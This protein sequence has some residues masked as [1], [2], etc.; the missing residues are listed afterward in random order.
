MSKKSYKSEGK[1][2]VL[3]NL[4]SDP[5]VIIDQKGLFLMANDMF[6]KET[7]LNPKEL[8]GK[9]FLNLDI[10]P[11]KSNAVLLENLSAKLQGVNVTPYEIQFTNASGEARFIEVKGKIISYAGQPADLVVFH[12]VTRTKENARRLKEYAERMEALVAEKVKEIKESEEKFRAISTYAKDAI[13]AADSEGEIVY[14]N[15]AAERIF[16]YSQ[17][18]VVGKSVLNLIIPPRNRG[19]QQIFVQQV[20]NRQL[21]QGKILEFTALRKDGTEFPAELSAAMMNFENKSCLLGIV[22]DVSERKKAEEALRASE[23]KLRAITNSVFDAVCLFDEEDTIIHWNAAAERIFGYAEKE[24]VGKKVS[25]T[26]VPARFRKAHCELAGKIAKG[27][28]KSAGQIWEFPALKKD[29]AEFPMELS[30]A[31]LQLNSKTYVTAIA[32]DITE[33]KRIEEVLRDSE[34]RIRGIFESSPDPITVSSADATIIDCNSAA[35]KTFGYSTKSEVIGRNVFEFFAERERARAAENFA[36]QGDTV[37]NAEYIFQ[38]KNGREFPGELSTSP[39]LNPS[40]KIACFVSTLKDITERKKAKEKMVKDQEELNLII[41]SSPVIIFYKDKEG[42]FLRVNKAFAEARQ[43]SPR[44]FVGKTVFDFYSTEIAQSMKNDDRECVQ[45]GRPKFG[46]LEQYESTS[47]LRWVQTDKIP[48]FGENGVPNGLVGFALD[49]TERKKT[50]ENLR[51]SEARFRAISNS[52]RDAIILVNDKE[53][54]EYWNPAAEKTF[55]YTR[56]E[57]IGQKLHDLIVPSSIC[58]EGKMT[59]A[60]GVKRFAQT[61]MGKFIGETVE[62]T[63][64]RKDGSELPIKLSLSPIK[65]GNIWHAVGVAK[66]ITEEKQKEQMAREYSD[67]LEKAIAARTN[68]LQIAQASLI[69]L[70]HVAAIGELAGMVGHDLRNPLTGI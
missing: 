18:E 4:L 54:I 70:E 36:R 15:P 50:Q 7:G 19:F 40:G 58:P 65:L 34:E 9:P 21:S 59:I 27:K 67:K 17:E 38:T 13:V 10:L 49:I 1:T 39:V 41:N 57:A 20:Q 47:G 63:A 2:R 5:A 26:I 14:W 11:A 66:D 32:R 31:P 55:G 61:G 51:V 16:G 25:A 23:A 42:K 24:I 6:G 8:I 45:S 30:M 69:K 68:K 53:T 28:E 43:T 37:V 3:L 60:Q 12:D 46:I 35:L 56:E 52:V 33:R 29:G 22:R 44:E 48:T 62:L 64:C